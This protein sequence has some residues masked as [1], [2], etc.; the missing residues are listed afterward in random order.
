MAASTRPS[1]TFSRRTRYL[2]PLAIA[3]LIITASSRSQVA[4][5]NVTA[6]DDKFAHFGAYGLL[7]TLVCR[8]RG[9]WRA[10]GW[11]LL[12]VS[13]FGASDEWHQSFVPGRSPDVM[14]WVADTTGAALAVALY[15]G[16]SRY[17]QLLEWPI[18]RGGRGIETAPPASF[19]GGT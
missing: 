2:W 4:S 19:V 5:P 8:V 3:L 10:A 7:A 9:G 11:S 18:F 17:R 12:A 16:W 6:I 13:A 1:A 14:D 15:A